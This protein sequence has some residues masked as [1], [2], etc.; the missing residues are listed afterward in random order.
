MESHKANEANPLVIHNETRARL[1]EL[2]SLDLKLYHVISD[3]LEDG[4]YG[5]IPKWDGSRFMLHSSTQAK[6]IKR[7]KT[8]KAMS[9]Q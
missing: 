7:L 3:C 1:T 6:R 5:N 9:N 8:T 2:N 4:N